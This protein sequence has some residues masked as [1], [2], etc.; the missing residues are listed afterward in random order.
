MVDKLDF[1]QLNEIIKEYLAF[2]GM[3]SALDCFEAEEKTKQFSIGS[4]I[5]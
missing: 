1:N 5:I 3:E 2:H 4:G